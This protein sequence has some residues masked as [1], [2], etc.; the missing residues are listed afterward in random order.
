MKI[1]PILPTVAIALVG[2]LLLPTD[3]SEAAPKTNQGGTP[4]RYIIKFVEGKENQGVSALKKNGA[5]VVKSLDRH[6]AVAATIPA[7][8][9]AVIEKNPNIEFV[10]PDGKRYPIAIE[11]AAPS[12]ADQLATDT[13]GSGEVI[14]YGYTMVQADQLIAGEGYTKKVCVIDS[15]YD[16]THP[17]KA[18]AGVTFGTDRGAGPANEDGDGHGTHVSGTISA[19]ANDIGII[20]IYP[21]APMHIVRVFGEDG[22]WAY[23]SDLIVAVDDCI[24]NGSN[25]ISM[26]LGG[27]Y[28]YL[29]E[30]MVFRKAEKEGILS[31]AAAGNDGNNRMS[32]PASYH[33]VL[34]VG[35]VDADSNLA[36]FSQRNTHVELAAPGVSV[37]STV[38]VGSVMDISLTVAGLGTYSVEPMDGF[39]I[40]AA[41]VEAPIMDCGLG[42]TAEDCIGNSGD[43]CLIER[44]GFSF[45]QKAVSCETA[46]GSAAVVFNSYGNEGPVYGTLGGTKVGIPAVGMDRVDGLE[47]RDKGGL[48][49]SGTLEFAVSDYDYDYFSG[50]S[51]A[52]PHV[53]GVAALV[54]SNHPSCSNNEI[55]AAMKATAIDL[56][57][58][59]QDHYFG[60]GL[61]Q[62][63]AASDYLG[64]N[65]CTGN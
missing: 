25:I 1:N 62:A 22:N 56:G 63:K 3:V 40:P 9:L 21:D 65:G 27:D 6:H 35:A 60:Y 38:P 52:T 20:G 54:W 23:T 24:Q 48:A 42:E 36:G 39:E 4:E 15:G 49:S 26:S 55:R 16:F 19:L 29:L 45:A 13:G 8:R 12:G 33:S 31:I 59:G 41:P 2:A 5:K 10:E 58:P 34:S 50:T 32:Y 44:G 11:R 7:G 53:S 30:N 47:I 64:T 17:D 57:P 18:A 51:M 28:P 46:E 43:I 14:P 37:L 61:V